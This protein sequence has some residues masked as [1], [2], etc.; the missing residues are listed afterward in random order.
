MTGETFMKEGDLSSAWKDG[1]PL[2]DLIGA[3]R[4]I[5]NWWLVIGSPV[6]FLRIK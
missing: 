3:S 4:L 6:G 1:Q 2:D 5:T